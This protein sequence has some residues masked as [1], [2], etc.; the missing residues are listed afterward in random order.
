MFSCPYILLVVVAVLSICA[1]TCE[2]DNKV[3][4]DEVSFISF[5]K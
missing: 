3:K 5:D 4:E 2:S 1:Q